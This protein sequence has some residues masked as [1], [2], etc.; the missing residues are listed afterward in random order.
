M[1]GEHNIHQQYFIVNKDTPFQVNV[2]NR[3]QG[4]A[5]KTIKFGMVDQTNKQRIE[6]ED[7]NAGDG[8]P[9]QLVLFLQFLYAQ[10]FTIT[11]SGFLAELSLLIP[12]DYADLKDGYNG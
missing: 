4:E 2:R 5:M 12:D 11:Y 1:R 7:Y 6:M 9:E 10:G 8:W 3:H